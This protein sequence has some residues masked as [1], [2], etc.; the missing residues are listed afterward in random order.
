MLVVQIFKEDAAPDEE[1]Y[2]FQHARPYKFA[3]FHQRYLDQSL[4]LSR[5]LKH[6]NLAPL[7]GQCLEAKPYLFLYEAPSQDLKVSSFSSH[8][9]TMPTPLSLS[10]LPPGRG[11]RRR[12]R[13]P[14]SELI[15]PA[16]LPGR[17]RP[18]PSPPTWLRASV[19]LD[20]LESE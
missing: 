12:G 11:E 9:K 7:V 16:R 15:R 1:A 5:D 13:G 17:R 8:S 2:F 10:D 4:R 6:P 19:S 14:Q 20:L 3:A 18:R